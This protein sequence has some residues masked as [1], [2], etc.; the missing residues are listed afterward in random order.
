M[1]GVGQAPPG[2]RKAAA[3]R[4]KSLSRTAAVMKGL[5]GPEEGEAVASPKR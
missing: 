4:E 3:A 2:E 1:P 5:I